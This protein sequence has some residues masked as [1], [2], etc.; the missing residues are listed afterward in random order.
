MLS[1][2]R[3]DTR[4]QGHPQS[5]N[6][7]Q[8]PTMAR[9]YFK[10]Q[11]VTFFSFAYHTIFCHSFAQARGCIIKA[12]RLLWFWVVVLYHSV[13][14]V[15]GWYFASFSFASFYFFLFLFW[16]VISFRAIPSSLRPDFHRNIVIL[17]ST[18]G[19]KLP[20]IGPVEIQWSNLPNTT[21]TTP[22]QIFSGR[23]THRL[24]SRFK[25]LRVY[26]HQLLC[27]RW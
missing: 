21:P 26:H 27:L 12:F 3:W 16:H 1:W 14:V 9:L 4:S 23:W 13:I 17:P 10:I 25:N 2:C 24:Q 15:F 18:M 5:C 6:S 7:K 8:L 19:T 20:K 22:R 11:K